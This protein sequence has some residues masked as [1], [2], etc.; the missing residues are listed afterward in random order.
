[1]NDKITSFLERHSLS[2]SSTDIKSVCSYFISE[3]KAG[4]E[5]RPS[6]L[7]MIN[8][9]CNPVEHVPAGEKVIVI[10]AGGTNLRTCLISF[11]EKGDSVIE[12]FRKSKMPG[13]GYEIS[14]KDFFK[15]FA[16]ETE[17]LIT[18]SDRI[19]FCFSYAAEILPDHDGVPVMLS[20]EINAPEVVGK[21]LGKELLA[22]FTR[23][24]YDVSSKKIIILNDTVST[25]LAGI[26][27]MADLGC[28]GCIGFILG[29]GTNTA[30]IDNGTI[31]NE[32]SGALALT[33]GDI[34][35]KFLSSTLDP[36]K[37]KYEKM[38]SG[39]YL[40][41]GC[42]FVLRQAQEEGLISAQTVL[43]Q[44]FTSTDMTAFLKGEDSA[45]I[46][47][48]KEDK[49]TAQVLVK[50]YVTRTAKLVAANLAASVLKTEYGKKKP[51][52]INADGSTFYFV[53]GLRE[54]T[55]SYLDS[56]LK[57]YGRTAVFTQIES[58]PAIG[59]AIG[60]LSI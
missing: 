29:T 24:G 42:L 32:E 17:R 53:P 21:R 9:Y 48:N 3:M 25:L 18:K 39:K 15:V 60:A 46:I 59:S 35:E 50:A 6:S 54:Q 13:I 1:M 20:K 5:N 10:D 52:L 44:D 4:L 41:P 37:Y 58:S 49:E 11:D 45:L 38:I 26:S 34:D 40:G 31:I 7:P 12:D 14:A 43:P 22:E 47:E 2:E 28:E 8:S 16:D 51:V 56:F 27:K 55:V 36:E 57:E 30:Y 19:G 23:R 33:L